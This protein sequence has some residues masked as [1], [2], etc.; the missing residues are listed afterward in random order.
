MLK[1]NK[2]LKDALDNYIYLMSK[3]EYFEAHEVLEEAWHY[4]RISND[5]LSNLTKGLINGAIAF[6]HIKRDRK[7]SLKNAQKVIKSFDRYVGMYNDK[8]REAKLFEI[9]I[10]IVLEKRKIVGI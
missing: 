6:E 2:N 8:I 5:P 9:A 4:L 3:K 1:E 10:N 7:N